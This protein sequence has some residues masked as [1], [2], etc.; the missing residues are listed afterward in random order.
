MAPKLEEIRKANPHFFSD[1]WKE[2]GGYKLA[3]ITE[4]RGGYVLKLATHNG[5]FPVYNIDEELHLSFNRQGW[6]T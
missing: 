2:F 5:T 4:E 6:A 1:D 3:S